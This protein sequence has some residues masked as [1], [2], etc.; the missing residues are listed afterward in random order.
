MNQY[1]WE[2]INFI[3]EKKE[4]QPIKIEFENQEMNKEENGQQIEEYQNFI[5]SP[6][7]LSCLGLF[8]E[9]KLSFDSLFCSDENSPQQ[10]KLKTNNYL[11]NS[12][13]LVLE[14]IYSIKFEFWKKNNAL[15]NITAHSFNGKTAYLRIM[16]IT[17]QHSTEAKEIDWNNNII[18]D[19]NNSENSID[20]IITIPELFLHPLVHSNAEL[21]QQIF[22]YCNIILSNK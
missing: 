8:S 14:D 22:Q 2:H 11:S 20:S 7:K 17:S 9:D 4:E 19:N 1:N 5:L 3:K 12:E 15:Y 16:N 18:N 6:S 13:E 21:M 10:K